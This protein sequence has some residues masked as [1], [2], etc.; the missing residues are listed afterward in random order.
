MHESGAVHHDIGWSERLHHILR[1]RLDGGGRANIELLAPHA[2]ETG[3][4]S[5]IEIGRN[6]ARAFGAE[7][8]ADGAPDAL[9]GRS[10]ECDFVR[11]ALGHGIKS[12]LEIVARIERSEIRERPVNAA[13]LPRVSLALNPGYRASLPDCRE[14]TQ[15]LSRGAAKVWATRW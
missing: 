5:G 1:E 2:G 12:R 13:K 3:E 11:E 8:F 10:Y 14:E 9:P 6:H 15:W 7:R 4:L